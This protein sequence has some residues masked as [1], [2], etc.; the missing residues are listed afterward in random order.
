[1]SHN[2]KS[3]LWPFIIDN[4]LLLVIGTVAALLWANL[5]Y[6]SYARVAHA[7]HFPVNDIGRAF[8]FA[9]AT[10][11]GDMPIT[12]SA[13]RRRTRLTLLAFLLIGRISPAPWGSR[14]LF[15]GFA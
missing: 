12:A 3:G 2:P 10:I 5:D 1:M 11:P 13:R 8:F 15:L 14:P 7:L 9:L 4:Y 6:G